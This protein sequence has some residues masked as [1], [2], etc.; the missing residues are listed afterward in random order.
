MKLDLKNKKILSVLEEDA[1]TPLSKIASRVGLSKQVV[2][3]RIRTMMKNG[4]IKDFTIHCDLTKLG[5][6]TFGVYLRLRKLTE[7]TESRII[8]LLAD[9]PFTRWVVV[10]EGKWDMAFS[11]S[12]KNIMDF[13]KQLEDIIEQIGENLES[14]DTNIIVSLQNFY[15]DLLGK[16]DYDRLKNV[17]SEFASDKSVEKIDALDMKIMQELQKNSRASFVEIAQKLDSSADTIRYR[18]KNLVQRKILTDFKTRISLK[19]MGFNWYQLI[20]DLK[21]LPDIEEKKFL[22][23]MITIPHITYVVRCIGKWDFELHIYAQDNEEFRTILLKIR[24]AL[25]D[26]IIS[27]DTMIMFTRYKSVSIPDGV[28][29]EIIAE[30]EGK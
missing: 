24:D 28:A 23:Q 11:M 29:R 27:Y 30:A 5:Y 14:Y 7:K 9:H 8:K 22:N 26:F 15:I 21:R 17:W 6:S 4:I 12:S 3:Y 2:D 25:S 16:K 13:H 18:V 20:L 10:C 1:R 19:T